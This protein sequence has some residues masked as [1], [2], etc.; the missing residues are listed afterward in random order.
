LRKIQEN[1]GDW[2]SGE[3]PAGTMLF[4]WRVPCK[5]SHFFKKADMRDEQEV[6]G[7]GRDIRNNL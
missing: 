4:L 2:G 1:I 3:Y 7:N 5:K 6:I